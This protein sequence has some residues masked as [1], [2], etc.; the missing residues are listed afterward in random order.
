MKP[1]VGCTP[2]GTTRFDSRTVAVKTH[3]DLF[4]RSHGGVPTPHKYTHYYGRNGY[5]G[6]KGRNSRMG[7][8]DL[9]RVRNRLR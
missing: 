9:W 4:G 2:L 7:W 8:R 6:K 5:M 1:W 3:Y